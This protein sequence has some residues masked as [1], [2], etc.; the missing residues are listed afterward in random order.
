MTNSC[1]SDQSLSQSFLLSSRQ[2]FLLTRGVSLVL[3]TLRIAPSK[4][5]ETDVRKPLGK[6]LLDICLYYI[7]DPYQTE[8]HGAEGEL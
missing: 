3:Q 6:V 2:V 4:S 1:L 8:E 7:F 5:F